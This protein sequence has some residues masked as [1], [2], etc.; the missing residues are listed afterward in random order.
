M[1]DNGVRSMR[2]G[3]ALRIAQIR[4]RCSCVRYDGGVAKSWLENGGLLLASDNIAAAISNL[5]Q[6][7]GNDPAVLGRADLV[8]TVIGYPSVIG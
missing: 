7:V 1:G 2:T 5:K 4:V 8:S 6:Q 3:G